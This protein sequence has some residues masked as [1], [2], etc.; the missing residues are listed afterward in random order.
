MDFIGLHVRNKQLLATFDRSN[1]FPD[2]FISDENSSDIRLARMIQLA[3]VHINSMCVCKSAAIFNIRAQF[4]RV[5]AMQEAERIET[6]CIDHVEMMQNQM[7]QETT[8]LKRTKHRSVF[9]SRYYY[10]MERSR[11]IDELKISHDRR[12]LNALAESEKL[13]VSTNR[14][15]RI[16][17]LFVVCLSIS[18]IL[19]D[20]H[21]DFYI[22]E[23]FDGTD[24]CLQ[25]NAAGSFPIGVNAPLTAFHCMEFFMAN[26]VATLRA[27]QNSRTILARNQIGFAFKAICALRIVL[28]VIGADAICLFDD[29][30]LSDFESTTGDN[31]LAVFLRLPNFETFSK[32]RNFRVSWKAEFWLNQR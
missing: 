2:E 3:A 24:D 9:W 18:E 17:V 4:G 32:A 1:D 14:R 26:I 6:I 5:S 31:M 8:F 25:N 7:C 15:I 20:V 29:D 28:G 10:R 16:V 22:R 19:N 11:V 30:G 21:H 27:K 12:M 13:H 23:R